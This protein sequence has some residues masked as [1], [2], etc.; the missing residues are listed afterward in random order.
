[1][2]NDNRIV[3]ELRLIRLMME[4]EIHKAGEDEEKKWGEFL[5]SMDSRHHL[6]N[7]LENIQKVG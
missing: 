1:M 3:F 7:Y 5:S 6:L 2:P 4:F